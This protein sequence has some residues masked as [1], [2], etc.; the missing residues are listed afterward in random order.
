MST[1]VT[2]PQDNT[3]EALF[4]AKII[5]RIQ[6]DMGDLMP[7]KMISDVI[8]ASIKEMLYRNVGNQYHPKKWI[9]DQVIEV[10]GQ[11]V[12][13]TV[14]KLLE[15]QRAEIEAMVTDYI[16]N[17]LPS[18]IA[19]FFM[20]MVMAQSGRVGAE[21]GMDIMNNVRNGNIY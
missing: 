14:A 7:D 13:D 6:S 15:D 1:D 4:K 21:M 10:C 9:E 5:E 2:R 3:P 16:K 11:Q 20:N 18:L 17:N 12:K 8:E 19:A